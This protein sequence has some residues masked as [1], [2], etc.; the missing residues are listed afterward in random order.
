M[1]TPTDLL[2]TSLASADE[3][4]GHI[5]LTR[6]AFAAGIAVAALLGGCRDTSGTAKADELPDAPPDPAFLA[7]SQALTGYSDLS[8]VTAARIS[9][10]FGRLYPSFKA[11]FPTL[12]NLARDH[13]QPADLL[14]AAKQAGIEEPALAIVTAWYKGT[15][16][17]GVDA[18]SVAY[19]DALMNRPVAD[20]LYPPTYQ[21][22]GPG[23]WAA[24]PPPV[25]I[26][27][28]VEPPVAT[29]P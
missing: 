15:V 3:G 18:I 8:P 13:G 23:W 5:R 22:G 6:R 24:A 10:G 28:P 12:T 11:R 14:A 21:M 20:A 29:K 19:A 7:L 27:P 26:A 4:V 1:G 9:D 17:Q 2:L 16:G 25:G